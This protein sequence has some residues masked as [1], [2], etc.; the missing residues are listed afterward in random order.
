MKPTKE[1]ANEALDILAAQCGS[2]KIRN[3]NKKT[4]KAFLAMNETTEPKQPPGLPGNDENEMPG[5]GA[6]DRLAKAA[7]IRR[8]IALIRA[9]LKEIRKDAKDKIAV[10][11]RAQAAL[12]DEPGATD[13]LTLFELPPEIPP[14]AAEVLANPGL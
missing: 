1:Q 11:E 9:Q 12:L 6:L 2:A 8:T 13:Q 4:L 7:E 3:D 14:E 5:G 10:L